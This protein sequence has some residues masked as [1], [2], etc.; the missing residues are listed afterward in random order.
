MPKINDEQ[1]NENMKMIIGVAEKLFFERGYNMTSVNDIIKE[2]QISKGRFYIYFES[3]EDLFFHIIMG[4]D[5]QIIHFGK[6]MSASDRQ[7]GNLG[8]YIRYRLERYYEEENRKRA[9]YTVEFWSSILLK[10]KYKRM[11]YSRYENFVSDIKTVIQVSQQKVELKKLQDIDAY[12]HVLMATI[13]G[14]IFMDTV[15][16]KPINEKTI[17]EAIKVFT[18]YLEV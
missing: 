7:G 9:K 5:R 11:L 16:E 4:V 1:R 14:L 13:D 2:A 3:K 17:D 10:G 15:L 12:I 8:N 18:N 6:D